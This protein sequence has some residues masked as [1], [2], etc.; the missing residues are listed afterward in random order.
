MKPHLPPGGKFLLRE[1]PGGKVQVPGFRL[2]VSGWRASVIQLD[3][4]LNL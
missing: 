4:H 3:P 2:E 1:L